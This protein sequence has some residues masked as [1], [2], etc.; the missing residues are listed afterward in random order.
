MKKDFVESYLCLKNKR[1]NFT[2]EQLGK[3]AMPP[4]IELVACYKSLFFYNKKR[5]PQALQPKVVP[6]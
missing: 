1:R 2:A 3:F 4:V 5:Y 6:F